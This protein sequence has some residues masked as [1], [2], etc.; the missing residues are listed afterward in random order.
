MR[1]KIWLLWLWSSIKDRIAREGTW[2]WENIDVPWIN[3]KDDKKQAR[4]RAKRG[5]N[6]WAQW[7]AGEDILEHSALVLKAFL[8]NSPTHL[9]TA[10]IEHFVNLADRYFRLNRAD[11]P[12]DKYGYPNFD[13]GYRQRQECAE[14]EQRLYGELGDILKENGIRLWY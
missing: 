4:W 8:R 5:Y 2:R 12:V 1:I 9:D 3:Y 13:E 6:E 10:K 14:I 11:Y 7:A